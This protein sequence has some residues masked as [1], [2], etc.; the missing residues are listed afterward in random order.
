VHITRDVVFDE[1]AQ[2]DWS[3]ETDAKTVGDGDFSV[4][5]MV[6]STRITPK[7]PTAG[8]VSDQL[9]PSPARV[10]GSP[11]HSLEEVEEEPGLG[12]RLDADHDDAPLRLR[13]M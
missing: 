9:M 4:E 8:E 1:G 3:Q 11:P 2:W 13:S 7:E 12:D 5:Y 10:L 6:L